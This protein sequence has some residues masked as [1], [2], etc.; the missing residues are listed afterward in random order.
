MSLANFNYIKVSV[1]HWVH[2]NVHAISKAEANQVAMA[3][4]TIISLHK[5]L[6]LPR[7]G[8]RTPPRLSSHDGIA[9]MITLW[10]YKKKAVS[11]LNE[12]INV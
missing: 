6:S 9:L 12:L 5:L 11:P 8:K 4:K 7:I 10:W 1:Y 3:G 2:N